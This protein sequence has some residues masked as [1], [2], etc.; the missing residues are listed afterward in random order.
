MYKRQDKTMCCW[1]VYISPVLIQ[2]V[3]Q[4][5]E[6]R[7][8]LAAVIMLT[9]NYMI[10]QNSQVALEFPAADGWDQTN[11]QI[12]CHKDRYCNKYLT[13]LLNSQP[14]QLWMK[15]FGTNMSKKKMQ[16]VTSKINIE[17]SQ[18]NI[19]YSVNFL[20]IVLL[21]CQSAFF[22]LKLEF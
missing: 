13:H 22:T 10:F 19:F 4:E 9:L 11:K 21:N 16:N 3:T 15:Q 7:G 20:T 17:V 12:Y 6:C 1:F 5:L 2:L 18:Q 14:D 8:L